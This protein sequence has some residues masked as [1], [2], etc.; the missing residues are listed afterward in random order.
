MN[1]G[2]EEWSYAIAHSH[3]Y[4]RTLLAAAQLQQL[5][6]I[7]TSMETG[8]L[9]TGTLEVRAE[10]RLLGTSGREVRL[11][12]DGSLEIER[13]PQ[14]LPSMDGSWHRDRLR[15]QMNRDTWPTVVKN[16][17]QAEALRC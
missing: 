14:F 17:L 2:S 3:P 7:M 13:A 10:W 8:E 4:T 6:V 11:F 15:I 12:S 9:E 16:V 5:Q 1:P